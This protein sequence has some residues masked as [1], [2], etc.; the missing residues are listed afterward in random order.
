MRLGYRIFDEKDIIPE[1][2]LVQI[3]VWHRSE[4]DLRR[5]SHMAMELKRRGIGFVIHPA[6]LYLS[7]TREG[8]REGYLRS[9]KRYAEM[10]DLALIVHDE[11]LPDG[12]TLEGAWREA[13]REALLELEDLC[14]V[15]IENA[16]DSPNALSFW[17]EFASSITF[18]VG[19]FRSAGMDVLKV[20]D[21]LG[22][23]HIGALD[24]IHLHRN[25]GPRKWG[26]TDH[27][28]LISGCPEI[29]ALERLLEIK[30][31]LKVIL[32]VDGREIYQSME[33]LGLYL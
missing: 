17:R 13:Y 25:N 31:D 14:R 28:G 33:A 16:F 19:H 11:T 10:A 2:D 6:G 18:D 4:K 32:E 24:F 7:E 1:L 12:R 26:I 9:L 30:D 8:V 20:V 29:E 3:T 23:E 27:W 15:S 5:T 22:E 21:Q